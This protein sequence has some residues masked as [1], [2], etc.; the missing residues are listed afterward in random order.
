[1]L[2]NFYNYQFIFL[3]LDTKKTK[4]NYKLYITFMNIRII[5]NV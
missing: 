5:F 3:R 1:M 4:I 2:I